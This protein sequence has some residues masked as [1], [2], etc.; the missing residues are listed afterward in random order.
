[1]SF[2]VFMQCFTGGNASGVPAT[3]VRD[4]FSNF[5]DDSEPNCW[6]LWY[7]QAN[8]CHVYV[9]RSDDLIE[10]LTVDRPCGDGRLWDSIY[11]V[12]QLGS[13]VLYFPAPK[14]PL[15]MADPKH[16][17]QLPPDMREVLGPV[18]HVRSGNEILEIIRSS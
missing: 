9:T 17:E 2:E 6:H 7:D 18:C 3:A 1:M 12:L 5:A 15:I 10:A 11:R 13:W 16:A 4:A 8:S 14:P